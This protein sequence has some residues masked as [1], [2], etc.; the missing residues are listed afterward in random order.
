M[1]TPAKNISNSLTHLETLIEKMAYAVSI[2]KRIDELKFMKQ[3]KEQSSVI[4]DARRLISDTERALS[5]WIDG[6]Q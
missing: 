5:P 3:I 1:T 4:R 2:G 6:A